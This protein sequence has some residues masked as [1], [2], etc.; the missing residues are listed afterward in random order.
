MGSIATPAPPVAFDPIALRD[1][2]RAERD[3]RLRSD[4]VR[5]YIHI[6]NDNPILQAYLTDPY[7]DPI[8]RDP[9]Q[10]DVDFLI[11]GG[12]YGGQLTAAR[13]IEAGV[14]DIRIIEKAGDF[15]GT[16]Y[17]NRYPGAACDIESYVYMPLLEEIGYVP[18]EKYARAP[19]L[20]QHARNIGKHYGLYEKALFQT[21]AQEMRWLEEEGRWEVR[22]NWGDRIRARFVA[23]ASGPLT[24]PKLPGV[25]G[26][27]EF[28]GHSF[29]TSRWDYNYTGGTTLGGLDKLKDKRVGIIGTGATAVQ[30]VPHLGAAAKEL[31]VFQRTPSSVDRRDNRPTDPEW[32]KSL[33]PGWQQARMDNFNN[34]VS[35]I[36]E[37]EDLVSD[38]WTDIIRKLFVRRG[39]NDANV[40]KSLEAID[41]R[42]LADFEKMEEV[43][44]A[45]HP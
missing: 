28:K 27:E 18:K 32:A 7:V 41:Q 45:P 22:T 5:Q 30:V 33:Q 40:G 10:E 25:P 19:E 44:S 42:Q 38:G 3:K 29:H 43:S 16:W 4:G 6:R 37:K 36:P 17:W 12:G 20:L 11:V 23:T 14:K 13:L 21:E 24:R 35:G 1:K 8:Q 31:F 34:I 9:I 2:Y 39:E 26:I 15:G